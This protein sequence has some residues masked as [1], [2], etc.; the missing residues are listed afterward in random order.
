MPQELLDNEHVFLLPHMG[1]TTVETGRKMEI[2]NMDNVRSALEK[3]VLISQVIEQK[4]LE[5]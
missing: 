5:F 2:W 3:G 1:T 4:G